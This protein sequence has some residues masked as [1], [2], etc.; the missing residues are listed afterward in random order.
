MVKAAKKLPQLQAELGLFK[1]EGQRW[2]G[3]IQVVP[4]IFESTLI[5]VRFYIC[6][7]RRYV[8]IFANIVAL[9]IYGFTYV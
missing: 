6:V 3:W 7:Y 2:I 9:I 8:H 1:Q 5:F 4:K